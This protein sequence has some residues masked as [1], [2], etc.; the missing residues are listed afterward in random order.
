MDY[1]LGQSLGCLRAGA[2][3]KSGQTTPFG[4]E[5]NAKAQR[6]GGAKWEPRQENTQKDRDEWP[7]KNA[8]STRRR[9]NWLIAKYGKDATTDG[10][11]TTDTVAQRN[12]DFNRE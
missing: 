10:D 3:A 11:L 5:F 1:P 9:V 8:R 6:R 2:R 7:Q 4:E 12:T